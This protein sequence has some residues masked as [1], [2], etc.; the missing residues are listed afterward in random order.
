VNDSGN[1]GV[2]PTTGWTYKVVLKRKDFPAGS[3]IRAL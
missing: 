3:I 2:V 1:N